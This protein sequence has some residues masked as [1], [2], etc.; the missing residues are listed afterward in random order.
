MDY[1]AQTNAL[2][3]AADKLLS[4]GTVDCVIGL[5]PN[6]AVGFPTPI[7]IRNPED[8]GKL[9]WD[10]NCFTNIAV[11]LLR[12][13][14]RR[15]IAAKACD[16]RS[17][18][19]LLA[20]NQLK[21]DEIYI[22]GMQCPGMIKDG[23]PAPGCDQCPSSVPGISDL[24]IGSDGSDTYQDE[25]MEPHGENVTEWMENSTDAEKKER[26]LK[27]IDKCILCFTCRQACP[28][29]YCTACFIDRKADPW[30]QIDADRA[31][32]IAFHLTRA[33]HLAG[34]CTDCCACEKVCASGVNLRYLYRGIIEFVSDTYGFTTGV[35]PDA[36]PVMNSFT[37]EDSETGFLGR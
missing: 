2:R 32:K 3:A 5:T 37:S 9:V 12:T 24:T 23:E 16:V 13:T 36:R 4:E 20:E 15:A 6:E 22:I 7:V 26:F 8:A 33:M 11:Y 28:A 31:T 19:N 27:E 25:K 30:R 35:D 10:E 21:R 14:G 1:T 18:I 17:I 29:C 34:R